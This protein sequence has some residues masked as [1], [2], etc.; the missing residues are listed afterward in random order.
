VQGNAKGCQFLF[1]RARHL[2][3]SFFLI[4][5]GRPG[6]GWARLCFAD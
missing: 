6:G 4:H 2:T 5:R 1:D 3:S